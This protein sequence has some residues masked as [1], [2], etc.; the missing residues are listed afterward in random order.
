[1]SKVFASFILVVLSTAAFAKS[2]Q[3]T[4]LFEEKTKLETAITSQIRNIL[5]TALDKSTF[6]V[7]AQVTLTDAKSSMAHDE[8]P[9]KP[10]DLSVGLIDAESLIHRYQDEIQELST[11]QNTGP[12]FWVKSVQISV[13]LDSSLGKPYALELE[14]WMT[15]KVAADLGV[16]TKVF[17]DLI[18]DKPE[19]KENPKSFFDY[20]SQLQLL[21]GLLVLALTALLLL[22]LSKFIVS[23]DT[24]EKHKFTAEL[25]QNIKSK[26]EEAKPVEELEPAEEEKLLALAETP[27]IVLQ[28]LASLQS[29]IFWAIHGT[30]QQLEKILKVWTDS[31]KK[32]FYKAACLIDIL[33]AGEG[34]D[35]GKFAIAW[36]KLIPENS[37]KDMREI[38]ESMA[39]LSA[40]ER[41]E[42][43]E[44]VYWDIVSLK[45]LGAGTLETPF[46]YVGRLSM[47]EIYNVVLKQDP[48]LQAL[49]V[50]H[51]NEDV[52]NDFIKGISFENKKELVASCYS[53]DD[54]LE[55]DLQVASESLKFQFSRSSQSE[56][57]LSIPSMTPRILNSFTVIE[58][59]QVLNELKEKLAGKI[60]SVK[61]SHPSLAFLMDWPTHYLKLVFARAN[62]DEVTAFLRLYPE[63]STQILALCPPRVQTIVSDDLPRE[64]RMT[65]E[66]KEKNLNSLKLKMLQVINSENINLETL[67][68][69]VGGNLRAA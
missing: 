64:D 62:N 37:R 43:L 30:T 25:N 22:A 13:G 26:E 50:L 35:V 65:M 8:K 42:I 17:V 41:I 61:R 52:R 67:F 6:E 33:L 11:Q 28:K 12:N 39:T 23:K 24:L 10:M 56:K 44:D 58:E 38:F 3:Q 49:T 57:T 14:K 54:V 27:E 20:V 53:M 66:S 1:M 59:I 36:D 34:K 15:K 48:K 18:K 47:P 19:K 5:A 21:I 16:K 68:A 69:E 51:M 4:S 46:D 32:G 2:S 55:T 9:T 29:K 7:S 60:M 31:G 63:T 40:E 45:T